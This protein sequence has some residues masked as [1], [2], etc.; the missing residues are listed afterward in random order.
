MPIANIAAKR[1]VV[2]DHGCTAACIIAKQQRIVTR[3]LRN[4]RGAV[5]VVI[6]YC[7]IDGLLRAD[8]VLVVG[9][10]NVVRSVCS[11]C[12]LSSVPRHCVAAVGGWI[13]ACIVADF[14]AVI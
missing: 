6:G 13:A 1:T 14:L 12:K 7:S 8:S 2:V 4:Q 5:V 10:G 3:D 9:I 11:C